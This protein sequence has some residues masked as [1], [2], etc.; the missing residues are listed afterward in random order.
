M[1]RCSILSKS[2]H[3]MNNPSLS[4]SSWTY[5]KIPAN[6]GYGEIKAGKKIMK[7]KMIII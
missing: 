6:N 3:D 5:Q 7:F 4:G 2:A 1:S